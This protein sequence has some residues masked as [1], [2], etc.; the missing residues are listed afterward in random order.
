MNYISDMIN[1]YLAQVWDGP[2]MDQDLVWP[3]TS[4]SKVKNIIA[5]LI[6]FVFKE[7][8]LIGEFCK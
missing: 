1:V 3:H 4:A 8:I 7:E 6:Y 2:V 5:P